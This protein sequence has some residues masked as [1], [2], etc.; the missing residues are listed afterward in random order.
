MARIAALVQ[1]LM[2][3]SRVRTSLEASG[4]EVEQDAELPDELDGIDLVVADLDAVPPERLVELGVPVVGFY[5]HTDVDTKAR[6][7]AAG[8]AV[9]I[10]RSRMVRELPELVDQAL[11]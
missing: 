8:L 6:A 7:E 10:P 9:A 11:G 5:Q 1:D 3:A 2:L 4:H